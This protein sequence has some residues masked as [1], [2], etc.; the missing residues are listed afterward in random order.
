M[1]TI[2]IGSNI[3][4]FFRSKNEQQQ[5][6]RNND[7]YIFGSP[8][9]LSKTWKKTSEKSHYL[10][11]FEDIYPLNDASFASNGTGSIPQSKVLG[12]HS[13]NSSLMEPEEEEESALNKSNMY[14]DDEQLLG[15]NQGPHYHCQLYQRIM[16][17]REAVMQVIWQ[18]LKNCLI[19]VF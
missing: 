18:K 17:L 2:L 15:K 19:R 1:K 5:T 7:H 6:D 9:L 3:W 4:I 8:A 11:V 13:T 14:Y 12:I 16:L 10:D